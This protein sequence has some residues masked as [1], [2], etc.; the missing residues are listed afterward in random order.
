MIEQ[1]KIINKIRSL[2]RLGL[3]TFNDKILAI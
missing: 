1:L 3:V 2:L